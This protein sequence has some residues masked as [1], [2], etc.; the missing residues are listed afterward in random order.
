MAK[1]KGSVLTCVQCGAEFRVPPSRAATATTC[2]HACAVHQRARS[3]ERKVELA[4]KGC[5]K[6]FQV[7]RSHKH[8][9]VFC[10]RECLEASP[11]TRAQ[12]ASRTGRKNGNWKGGRIPRHDGYIYVSVHDHPFASNG[13]VL[14]HRWIMERWLVK[15]DPASKFL[16][17]IDGKLRLS[18][19]F[20]VHHMDENKTNNRVSNLRCMTPG[21]H[22]VLHNAIRRARMKVYQKHFP[23]GLTPASVN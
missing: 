23:A 3:I 14:E 9:R 20:H 7:P 15:N 18:R 4:C 1:F 12:R 19:D 6:S 21:E 16:T 10:S 17:E 11:A 13:Y 8:R 2:S 5:G 22:K